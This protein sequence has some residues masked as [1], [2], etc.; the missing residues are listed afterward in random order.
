MM[1][2]TLSGTHAMLKSNATNW[3]KEWCPSCASEAVTNLPAIAMTKQRHTTD[4]VLHDSV[5]AWRAIGT[6][7]TQ[8]L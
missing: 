2:L 3:R 1:L 7:K 4:A 6:A 8:G 5:Y